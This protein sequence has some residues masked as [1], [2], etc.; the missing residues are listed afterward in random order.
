MGIKNRIFCLIAFTSISITASFAQKI[1]IQAHRG[2]M[3]LYPENTIVAMLNAMDWG[4]NT[5]EMDLSI[6]KD[7]QV[8][9]SHEQVMDHRY[10][11][12]PEGKYFSKADE[13]NY[14]LYEMSYNSIIKYDTGLK[15]DPRFP[16]RKKI[17][18]HKPLL[19]DL[20]DETE[21]YAKLNNMPL[22][23]YNIEIKSSEKYDRVFTPDYKEFTNLAMDV[24]LAKNI[25]E[26]LI[27]QCF[28]PRTLIYMREN[29]PQIKLAYL[30]GKQMVSFE[31]AMSKLNF[32]PEIF[33]PDY[34]L[35]DKKLVKAVH[36]K[37]MIILPWTV[38][39]YKDIQQMI[40]LKVDGLITNYPD[41]A[42]NLVHCS[43][44]HK[45]L[46]INHK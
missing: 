34:V 13:K 3:A 35:V 31:D 20:I 30:V 45:R 22:P 9:V 39:E 16:Q 23:Y 7:K 1:D 38:D 42:V 24:L 14:K 4:V 37:G 15:G 8:I 26:R 21:A 17:V 11:T 25:T 5:L 2:G 29:Y 36:K 19:S 12:T 33:S 6:S 10:V 28:D 43:Q 46:Y 44:K 32:T 40:D 27:I 18:A 41:R